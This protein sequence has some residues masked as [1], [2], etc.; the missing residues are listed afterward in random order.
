MEWEDITEEKQQVDFGTAAA[1]SY[2]LNNYEITFNNKE[3]IQKLVNGAI[4]YANMIVYEKS[5]EDERYKYMGATLE[6][7]LIINDDIY[8]GHA[9]DSRIY[10]LRKD[11]LKKLTKDHSYIENL[12]EDGKI[13]REEA[14]KH[15]DK[16]MVT[17]GIGNSKLVEPDVIHKKFKNGDTI[18]MCTDGLTNM[19]SEERIKE[20]LKEE[21]DVSKKLT[22]EA[23]KN[24]GMD[25]IT[26]VVI[27]KQE[28]YEFTRENARKQI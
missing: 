1:K 9:G 15:P 2:I 10:R 11:V 16:N 22:D 6:I 17:K 8:I 19:V 14:V 23:N 27:R 20:I 25:N 7:L 4:E 21:G 3:D 5:K 28:K 26:V 18:L 13:T 12:I 24:G